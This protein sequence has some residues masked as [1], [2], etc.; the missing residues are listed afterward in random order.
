MINITVDNYCTQ[1]SSAVQHTTVQITF[2]LIH[3]TTALHTNELANT[4]N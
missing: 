2:P 4:C 1:Y 3:A